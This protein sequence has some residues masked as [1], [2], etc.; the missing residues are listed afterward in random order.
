[1]AAATGDAD[2]CAGHGSG[3]H[4]RAAG[5]NRPR[6]SPTVLTCPHTASSSSRPKRVSR[7]DCSCTMARLSR[8]RSSAKRSLGLNS[9]S[10]APNWRNSSTS[11]SEGSPAAAPPAP[12]P[13]APSSAR[14]GAKPCPSRCGETPAGASAASSESAERPPA[15][16]WRYPRRACSISSPSFASGI[17]TAAGVGPAAES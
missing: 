4:R 9:R 14:C 13:A 10:A 15:R 12:K 3:C 1:M 7:A 17:S 6:R 11:G 5:C 16:G 2:G 8:C